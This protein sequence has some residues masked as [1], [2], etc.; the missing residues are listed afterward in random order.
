MDK[1]NKRI[2]SKYSNQFKKIIKSY[3]KTFLGSFIILVAFYFCLPKPLFKEPT[4]TIIY[5]TEGD[6]LGA[7]IAKDGQWRFP[8]SDSI[9]EKF[10]ECITQFEDAYF[11]KHPGFNLISI[12]KATKQNLKAKKII[13][14]A[15]TITQQVIRLSRKNK[16]RSFYEKIIELI[17]A[18]RMEFSFS[19]NEILNYYASYAP[20]GGNVVGLEA[21]SWRYYNRSSFDLSWAETATLAVLPNAPGLIYPGKNKKKLLKKRNYLLKKLK[22]NKIISKEIYET[23]LL[24]NLPQKPYP[25]PSLAPHLLTLIEKKHPETI[26]YTSIKTSIQQTANNLLKTH[27]KKLSKNEI[28]NGAVLILD[29]KTRKVL[30]Y[31]ANTATTKKHQNAVDNI[32]SARSTGSILKPFLYAGLYNEGL[33]L[34]QQLVKDIPTQMANFS[35]QNFDETYVGLLPSSLAL[36]KSL[37]IPAVRLLQK[38]NHKKFYDV[39]KSI[40]F[41]DLKYTANHYGLSLILGGGECSLWDITKNFAALNGTIEHYNNFNG[42]YFTNEFCEP[43]Y[44]KNKTINFGEQTKEQTLFDAS[45]IF[46]TLEALKFVNRPKEDQAWEY[47][48]S[49]QE[50]SWKTGT[51]YG[52]RDAWAVGVNNKYAI[53]V[54]VGNSDGEGRPGLTGVTAAAPLLFSVFDALPKA[55]NWLQKPISDYRLTKVCETSGYLASPYCKAIEKEVPKT[56]LNAKNCPYHKLIHLNKEKTF[57]VNQDCNNNE[58]INSESHLILPPLVKYYYQKSNPNLPITPPFKEECIKGNYQKMDFIYPSKNSTVYI[59]K[60]RFGER[61]ELILAAVHSQKDKT[62]FWYIDNEF[63][64]ETSVFHSIKTQPNIGKHTITIVDNDGNSI[65]RIINIKN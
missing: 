57:Q 16:K 25:L 10:K 40:G 19:K 56:G 8:K 48:S 21:A 27:Y 2:I 5:S 60:N 4:S 15:S 44:L 52:F 55:E 58:E 33:I 9:P 54:W 26:Q 29:I 12:I 24:E 53:G 17:L 61:S 32:Q 50:I 64:G 7:R 46:E 31:V 59:P 13:R 23:S 14:G 18:I 34:P 65:S 63:I 42:N 30:A 11:Y 41:K 6:L 37:N 22:E 47:F 45:S 20:F 3:P 28:Y 39:L 43:Q 38:Y 36:S 35:P 51:S 62:I 49:S 1:S